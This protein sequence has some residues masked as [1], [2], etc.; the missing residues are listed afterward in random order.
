MQPVPRDVG[1]PK[2][3]VEIIL[4]GALFRA[5]LVCFWCGYPEFVQGCR[6]KNCPWDA[7]YRRESHYP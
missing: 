7:D 3:Q 5:L 6:L 2:S 1:S 4:F